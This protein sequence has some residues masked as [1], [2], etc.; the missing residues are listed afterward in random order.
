MGVAASALLAALH[1]CCFPP[2]ERW[3]EAA[4]KEL[5][6]MPGCF[7]VIGPDADRPAG[8][9]LTRVAADEAELLT[10]GVSPAHRRGGEGG[11]LLRAVGAE[12][13]SRGAGRLFLEVATGNAAARALYRRAGFEEAGL[14]RRYYPNGDDALVLTARLP[15]SAG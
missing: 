14:R 9:A 10:I 6:L 11:R 12:A 3:A 2:G 1:E 13:A 8:L 15:F 5:L 7:G 4:M